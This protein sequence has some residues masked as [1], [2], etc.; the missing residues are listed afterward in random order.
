MDKPFKPPLPMLYAAMMNGVREIARDHGYALAVHG[1][2][3]TDFDLVAIPWT[4]AP[5]TPAQL[6]AAIKESCGWLYSGEPIGPERKPQGRLAWIIPLGLGT[7]ID[8]SV[9]MPTNSAH[10]HH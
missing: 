8:L 9:I 7:A 1:S 10:L 4:D 5:S 2:M 3:Q 6:V